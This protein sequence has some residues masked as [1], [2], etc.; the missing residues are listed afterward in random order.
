MSDSL[1]QKPVTLRGRSL[2]HYDFTAPTGAALLLTNH[3]Y[4]TGRPGNSNDSMLTD[5][6]DQLK[7]TRDHL[8][9]F[10]A[11]AKQ[12]NVIRNILVHNGYLSQANLAKLHKALSDLNT[13]KPGN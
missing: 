10:S 7:W 12:F 11:V 3:Y 6:I 5:P 13:K 4:F 8:P 9:Y 1:T 2:L